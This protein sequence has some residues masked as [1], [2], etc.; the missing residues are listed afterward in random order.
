MN[1]T[2]KEKEKKEKD[3]L[4]ELIAALI[5]FLKECDNFE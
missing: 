5:G 3:E 2:E 1:Q 4:N